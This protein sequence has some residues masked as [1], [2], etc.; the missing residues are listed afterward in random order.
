[1]NI[2]RFVSCL[3][4]VNLDTREVVLFLTKKSDE[5]GYCV[6]FDSDIL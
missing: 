2:I 1:M 4:A 6:K 5:A 3:I